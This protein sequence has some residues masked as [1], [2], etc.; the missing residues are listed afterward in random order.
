MKPLFPALAAAFVAASMSGPALAQDHGAS[1]HAPGILKKQEA[2]QSA[3]DFAPGQQQRDGTVDHARDAAPG[4]IDRQTTASI[5]LSLEQEAQI[6][7]LFVAPAQ[8]MDADVTVEVGAVVPSSITLQPVPAEVV[9][10]VPAYE[11]YEY[12]VAA[13]GRIVLVEPSTH[14]VVFVINADG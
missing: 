7:P 1:E 11:R 4:Q 13:D 8:Q 6:R 10:V 2:G 9:N 12:F 5:D 3:T 14:E